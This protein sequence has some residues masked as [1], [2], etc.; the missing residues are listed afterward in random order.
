MSFLNTEEKGV[1]F[2]EMELGE[3][4]IH[5]FL[6]SQIFLDG[7]RKVEYHSGCDVFLITEKAIEIMMMVSAG[8]ICKVAYK[9]WG[10]CNW[11]RY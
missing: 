8:G 1:R 9:H 2:E 11:Y 3:I 7:K 4:K 5:V 6:K 10:K